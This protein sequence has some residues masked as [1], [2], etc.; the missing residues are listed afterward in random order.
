MDSSLHNS[1]HCYHRRKYH[2]H[3]CLLEIEIRSKKNCILAVFTSTSIL[4]LNSTEESPASTIARFLRMDVFSGTASLTT[5]LFIAGERFLA[6]AFPFLHKV[7]TTRFYM[8]CIAVVWITSFLMTGIIFSSG[9]FPT[10]FCRT[11][12]RGILGYF[13][14]VCLIA[15]SALYT[16]I[17]VVFRKVNVRIPRNRRDQNKRLAKTLA[18]VT[19]TSLI[20][21]I[22]LSVHTVTPFSKIDGNCFLS[23]PRIIAPFLQMANSVINPLVY[24]YRMSEF[25]AVLKQNFPTCRNSNGRFRG[26]YECT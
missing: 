15:I 18:I 24:C 1:D 2:H 16:A 26:S 25:R 5:L 13:T 6:I 21:W 17:W 11:I 12:S 23:G 14:I 19:L 10:S 8:K 20:G 3:Y 4:K 7:I 9:I 22:P